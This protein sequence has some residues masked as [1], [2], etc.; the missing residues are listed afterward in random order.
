[1]SASG[2]GGGR[3]SAD[4]AAIIH[5]IDTAHIRRQMR[6]D[7]RPLLVA[8]P[9]EISAHQSFPQNESIRIV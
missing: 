5:A 7:P 1:M 2:V 6:L 8:Q 9:E 3:N 4:D